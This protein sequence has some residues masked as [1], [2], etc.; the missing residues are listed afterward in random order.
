MESGNVRKPQIKSLQAVRAFAFLEIFCCHCLWA[1]GACGVSIFFI[2][3]GFLLTYN[4]LGHISAKKIQYSVLDNIFFAI[5]KVKKL[6]PLHIIMMLLTLGNILFANNYIE[7]KAL[8]IQIGLNVFLVQTWIPQSVYFFSLNGVSWYLSTSLFTY[9]CFPWILYCI[10]KY[11]SRKS[12]LINMGIIYVIQF[13][14]GFLISNVFSINENMQYYVTYICPLYRVGDFAIGCNV[15]YLFCKRNVEKAEKEYICTI[16]ELGVCILIWIAQ[17]TYRN[18]VVP[19]WLKYSL[20]FT[21]VSILLIYIF[22]INEGKI[23]KLLINKV[24]FF[25]ATISPFAFLIHYQVIKWV[26]NF[27]LVIDLT[28]EKIFIAVLAMIVTICLS[29]VYSKLLGK[30]SKN[31]SDKAKVD[32]VVW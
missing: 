17:G 1:G 10:E 24:V 15:G 28:E 4:H 27:L 29:C 19:G 18:S 8:L 2:L 16:R 25:I 11:K 23:S 5:K 32:G 26:K 6:Y 20:I 14:I 22:A 31:Q 12:A 7:W 21:P 9:F 3:S 13:L 30:F